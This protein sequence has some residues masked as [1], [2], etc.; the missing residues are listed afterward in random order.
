MITLGLYSGK[1]FSGNKK[2]QFVIFSSGVIFISFIS[3]EA[4]LHVYLMKFYLQFGWS[5]VLLILLLMLIL[6][7]PFTGNIYNTV[8][9]LSRLTPALKRKVIKKQ[10]PVILPE[11]KESKE[12]IQT[13]PIIETEKLTEEPVKTAMEPVKITGKV[14]KEAEEQVQEKTEQ[15]L[16]PEVT[17]T[18]EEDIIKPEIKKTG[19]KPSIK[20]KT[21]KRNVKTKGRKK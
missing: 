16:L 18:K 17:N 4:V 14:N 13:P 19:R 11:I 1:L 20:G 15:E 6:V 10:E 7:S 12:E 2:L 5:A 21:T 8:Y 9:S 3:I